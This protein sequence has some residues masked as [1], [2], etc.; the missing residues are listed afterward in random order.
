MSIAT[1]TSL[2]QWAQDAIA[3]YELQNEMTENARRE[4][5]EATRASLQKKA[6][7]FAVKVGITDCLVD[8]STIS[9][10]E[11]KFIYTPGRNTSYGYQPE[12][13]AAFKKCED[14]GGNV[15]THDF[16][17]QYGLGGF[18]SKPDF[19]RCTNDDCPSNI[20]RTSY[21][22]PRETATDRLMNALREIV[23]DIVR[24]E[25]P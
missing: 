19:L 20:G 3:E 24:E 21:S 9:A 16:D 18:L 14:C 8:G 25:R 10:G 11:F 13:I 2:P 17:S 5:E 1:P 23:C 6:A 15:F 4:D 22:A 12:H 7:D